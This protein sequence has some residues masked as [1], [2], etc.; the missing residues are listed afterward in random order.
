[1]SLFVI[2]TIDDKGSSMLWDTVPPAIDD[3][4]R[5]RL[6]IE[7]LAG[8]HVQSERARQRLSQKE[9]LERRHELDRRGGPCDARTWNDLSESEKNE[10]AGG[11]I[12]R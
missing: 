10:L 6:S 11:N 8:I 9:W 3:S 1:V 12:K 5:L 4:E 2:L 7:C